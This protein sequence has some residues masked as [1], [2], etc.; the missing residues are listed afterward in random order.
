V[1]RTRL[2]VV[3]DE[4]MNVVLSDGP[5]TIDVTYRTVMH[6]GLL[7]AK[8]FF[9]HWSLR[10]RHGAAALKNVTASDS[11]DKFFTGCRENEISQ[12]F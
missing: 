7:L 10:S 1:L 12:L 4:T 6:F 8:Q 2:D 9:P 5:T 3:L 11:I